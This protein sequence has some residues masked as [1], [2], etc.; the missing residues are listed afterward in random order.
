LILD[1]VHRGAPF[2]DR[3]IHCFGATWRDLAGTCRILSEQYVT[4]Q[5]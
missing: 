2:P 3:Y 5:A 1:P 4:V